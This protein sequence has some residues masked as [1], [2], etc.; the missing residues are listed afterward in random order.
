MSLFQRPPGRY[1][2][3]LVIGA[4]LTSMFVFMAC[5]ALVWTPHSYTEINVAQ[6]L[7]PPSATHWLG[8]DQVGRDLF[9][10]MLKGS[11]NSISIA[12]VALGLGLGLGVPLGLTAAAKGGWREEIIMRMSDF[13]FAFPALLTAIMLRAL[14]GPHALNAMIAIGIF[15]I[16]VFARLTRSAA[17]TLWRSDFVLAARA[18]GRSTTMI[19]I[20]HILPNLTSLLIVQG[21]MQFAL[22]ILTE[23]GFSYLGLGTPPPEPSWGKMLAD[24]QTMVYIAPQLV[25]IPGLAIAL[26][27]LGLNLL[28]DGLRDLLDPRLKGSIGKG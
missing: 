25:I 5:L 1:R 11:H 18:I 6:R 15:N 24:A 13:S 28:G 20:E 4:L 2:P 17:L 16:P 23:A 27:V 3:N 14:Y 12:M 21:T 7:L 10:M 26:V 19:S 22:A 9:S 8:T